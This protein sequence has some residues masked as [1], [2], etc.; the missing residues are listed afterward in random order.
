[1]AAMRLPPLT[2]P[3]HTAGANGGDAAQDGASARGASLEGGQHP[4]QDHAGG[5]QAVNGHARDGGGARGGQGGG[6]A[7][8]RAAQREVQE[9]RR[10]H[11]GL[12]D[13][14]VPLLGG[15]HTPARRAR[16]A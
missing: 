7:D 12:L 1:M 6:A 14:R 2:P 16:L 9:E 10:L 5:R 11:A 13:G 3:L 8:G 15:P 4:P